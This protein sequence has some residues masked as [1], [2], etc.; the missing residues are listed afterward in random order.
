MFLDPFILAMVTGEGTV[1]LIFTFYPLGR[2]FI[3]LHVSW[4]CTISAAKHNDI[5]VNTQTVYDGEFQEI[6]K[7]IL[8]PEIKI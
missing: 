2:L 1:E 3:L 8:H 4:F 6:F 7:E 5:I